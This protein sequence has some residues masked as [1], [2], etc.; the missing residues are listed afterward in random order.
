M[1]ISQIVP[2]L[3][4]SSLAGSVDCGMGRCTEQADLRIDHYQI[5]AWVSRK[6]PH[7]MYSLKSSSGASKSEAM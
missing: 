2:A 4:S 7:S 6:Q 5:K 1:L 3:K